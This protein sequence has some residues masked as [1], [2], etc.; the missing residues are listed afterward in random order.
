M[1]L[2]GLLR[3]WC[4]G[5][6]LVVLKV[7]NK[8]V[9]RLVSGKTIVNPAIIALEVKTAQIGLYGLGVF[10]CFCCFL[11]QCYGYVVFLPVK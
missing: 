8:A 4:N 7:T 5:G 9:S 10:G 3:I 11:L 2:G 6:M 1:Y